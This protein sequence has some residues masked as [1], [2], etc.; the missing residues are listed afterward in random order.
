M[1][2]L[3]HRP[4]AKAEGRAAS[5]VARLYP[6]PFGIGTK[7]INRSGRSPEPSKI[8]TPGDGLPEML[9]HLRQFSV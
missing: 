9:T 1:E 2:T 8:D 7:A 3:E 4:G 6:T 5:T